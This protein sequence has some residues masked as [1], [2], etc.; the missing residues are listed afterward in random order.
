MKKLLFLAA[1]AIGFTACKKDKL[2]YETAAFEVSCST[3]TIAYDNDGD[4]STKSVSASFKKDLKLP[5]NASITVTPKAN[6]TFRFYL[7]N[8]EVYSIVV[9][10][11]TTFRYD[12]KANTLH[13][14]VNTRSFGAPKSSSSGK[15]TSSTCGATTKEGGRCQR[16]VKGGGYCWQ[17]K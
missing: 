15:E 5:S 3:C 16:V 2:E 12:Y 8:R 14:G 9:T 10:R 1:I 4:Q 17:H 11:P 7:T 13:D 6:T